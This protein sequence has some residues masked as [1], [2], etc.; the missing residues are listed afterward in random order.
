MTNNQIQILVT[1]KSPAGQ[2]VAAR[3]RRTNG[4]RPA[5]GAVNS[6]Y[7]ESCEAKVDLPVRAVKVMVAVVNG[8]GIG[9]PS[10]QSRA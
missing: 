8:L 4:N 5:V 10:A 3:E 7:A 2:E 9:N 6:A 1:I